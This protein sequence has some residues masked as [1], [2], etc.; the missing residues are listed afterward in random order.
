M[1]TG[2]KSFAP[3]TSARINRTIELPTFPPKQNGPANAGPFRFQ[4][5]L[6]HKLQG[7]F[8][9]FTHASRCIR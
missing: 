4:A 7:E 8:S 3:T 6:H 9:E 2:I 5:S 1:A